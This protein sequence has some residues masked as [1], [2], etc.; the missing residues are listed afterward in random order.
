MFSIKEANRQVSI[1]S[2]GSL[3]V[4]TISNNK[5]RNAYRELGITL[6]TRQF[7]ELAEEALR[8]F[9]DE[10]LTPIYNEIAKEHCEYSS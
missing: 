1:Q 4:L 6:T 7:A 3:I 8:L 2:E 9:K 5:K 10:C